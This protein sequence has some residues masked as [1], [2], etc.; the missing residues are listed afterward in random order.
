VEPNGSNYI[1]GLGFHPDPTQHPSVH[2]LS[3]IPESGEELRKFIDAQHEAENLA[4]N[5]NLTANLAVSIARQT[6]LCQQ[7]SCLPTRRRV[8]ATRPF[9][10]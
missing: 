7:Q 8:Q 2:E 9:I 3:L 5:V 4:V 10:K 6:R 1:V